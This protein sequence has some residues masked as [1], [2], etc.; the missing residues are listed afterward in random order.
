MGK[1]TEIL[2]K[3]LVLSCYDNSFLVVPTIT[4][5]MKYIAANCKLIVFRIN[6]ILTTGI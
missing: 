1:L 3:T 6:I 5:I 4:V 2:K